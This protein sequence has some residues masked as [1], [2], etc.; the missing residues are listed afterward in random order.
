MMSIKIKFKKLIIPG[1]AIVRAGACRHLRKKSQRTI[2]ATVISCPPKLPF[3]RR[4]PII[5]IPRHWKQCLSTNTAA[6][7]AH[8]ICSS[9]RVSILLRLAATIIA[10][11]AERQIYINRLRLKR[12]QLRLIIG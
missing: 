10:P 4:Y 7:R 1:V 2:V 12:L 9:D 11:G 5:L 3:P 8:R 6:P